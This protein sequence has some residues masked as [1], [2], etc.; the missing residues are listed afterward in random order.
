MAH[1]SHFPSAKQRAVMEI[2]RPV[3]PS[4]KVRLV[5]FVHQS[6]H[7]QLCTSFITGARIPSQGM[8]LKEGNGVG[9]SHF[10]G[11]SHPKHPHHPLQLLLPSTISLGKDT[12]LLGKQ[13]TSK[14]WDQSRMG[15]AD[16]N[17]CTA[18]LEKKE[19][20]FTP[21]ALTAPEWPPLDRSWK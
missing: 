11:S 4:L 9:A 16:T 15:G 21:T 18:V 20:N 10:W 8:R 13:G 2:S 19:E 5:C 14:P 6:Q 1:K 12:Q 7:F 3:W 17:T